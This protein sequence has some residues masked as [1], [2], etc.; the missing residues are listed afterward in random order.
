MK[1]GI[2]TITSVQNYGNRLQ[3]YALQR[4][5]LREG[6]N[7]YT[8]Y[9]QSLSIVNRAKIILKRLLNIKYTVKDQRYYNFK[10][11]NK[12]YIKMKRYS[13]K[14]NAKTDAFISGSDQVWNPDFCFDS[15]Y[16]LDFADKGKRMSYAASF[17]VETI[18]DDKSKIIGKWIRGFKYISVRELNAIEMVKKMSSREAVLVLDPTLL[19]TSDEWRE[20]ES[21]PKD[22]NKQ[23]FVVAYFLGKIPQEALNVIR[24]YEVNGKEIVILEGDDTPFNEIISKKTFA[25]NPSEFIWLFSHCDEVLTNSYHGTIFSLLFHKKFNIFKR[26]IKGINKNMKSRLD[27]LIMMLDLNIDYYECDK[28]CKNDIDYFDIDKILNQKR[29]DSINYLELVKGFGN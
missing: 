1:V 15:F 19:L 2:V 8:I 11:F 13:I 24:E 7:T 4:V 29:L 5:L 3:N 6:I 16:Y 21:Q 28:E 14:L 25:Y 12:K 26:E 27:S 23:S 9:R 10:K 17:G 22:F 18:S 20:I